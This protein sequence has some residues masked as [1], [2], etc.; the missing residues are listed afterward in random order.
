MNAPPGAIMVQQLSMQLVQRSFAKEQLTF[1]ENLRAKVMAGGMP[2]GE[3]QLQAMQ[4]QQTMMKKMANMRPLV[5]Q[6]METLGDEER[7]ALYAVEDK[8][9]KGEAP[10][11]EDRKTI[12]TAKDTVATYIATM[13][14][15]LMAMRQQQQQQG[16]SAA[17]VA[18]AASPAETADADKKKD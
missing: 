9:K 11:E 5:E 1:M 10:S 14:P 18:A 17:P 8:L 4:V 16:A 13:G 3:E 7:T 12:E 15:M 6:A 2:S